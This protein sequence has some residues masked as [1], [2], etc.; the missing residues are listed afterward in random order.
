MVPTSLNAWVC[1]AWERGSWTQQTTHHSFG[2][3]ARL[4]L[5][6]VTPISKSA[7][8]LNA[9]LVRSTC[10]EPWAQPAHVSIT[11]TNMHLSLLLHT[12]KHK[13]TLHDWR[14]QVYNARSRNSK[15]FGRSTHPF[16]VRAHAND[17]SW[18]RCINLICHSK[19][20]VMLTVGAQLLLDQ[21]LGLRRS[22]P[23]YLGS[24]I[25]KVHRSGGRGLPCDYDILGLSNAF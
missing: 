6:V 20:T 23:V 17:S 5:T 8:A 1:C 19:I 13:R 24:S 16:K 7:S 21:Q 18:T 12:V 25:Y 15:H 11:R 3:V 2:W 22:W 9:A 14:H 10:L 4:I